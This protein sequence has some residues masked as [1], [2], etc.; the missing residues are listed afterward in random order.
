MQNSYISSRTI[1]IVSSILLIG[2]SWV[3]PAPAAE[4][5]KSYY[6]HDVKQDSHGV[7]APW[8][9]GC[10][11]PLDERLR[12][13]VEVMKRYPWVDRPK[14]VVAAPDFV[15]NSHWSIKSDGT[16]L[17]PPTNDWMCGDLSQRAWS[18]VKGMTDYYAYSGD[19]VAF[20]Y[21]PIT[22][23]YILEFAQT[24]KDAPWPSFPIATPTRGKAYGK[25]DPNARNQLDL[26]AIVG[27]E[28]LRAY[29]LTGDKRYLDAARHWG[30]VFAEKCRFDP[31]IP[32][33]S[34]Y[35]DPS[36]VGWSDELTG[37]ITLILAFLDD[38]ISL[39]HTGKDDA[40]VRARDTGRKYISEVLL[41][42]WLKND[43]WG[44]NYWD[45]DNPVICGIVSMCGDYIMA[46]PQAFPTWKTDLRNVLTLI[47]N[48]NGT[49]P[50][51]HGDMY[52]GA[53]AFPESC[54]CCGTSLSYNQ[55]TAAPTLL[56][57]AHLAHDPRI[58]EIGRRMIIMACYDAD[59][60]GVVKDGL[61]GKTVATGEWSNLAHPWPLCQ[62]MEAIK[63]TPQT[64]SPRSEN[65]IIRTTSVV[66]SV[67]YAKGRI[68]YKLFDAPNE[69]I[70]VLRLSFK[71]DSIS[72]DEQDL[73]CLSELDKVGY[74]KK[75]LDAGDYLVTIRHDGKPHV[76]ITG[77]DPQT[78]VD[79]RDL[80]KSGNWQ[81]MG[82]DDAWNKSLSISS[83]VGAAQSINF[84]GNQVRVIGSVDTQGG[85]AEVYLDGEKQLT[86]IDCWSPL[87]RD[88]QVL[89]SHSGLPN[90]KHEL[91]IVVCGTGNPRSEGTNVYIDA[92]QY[93]DRTA[94]CDFGAGG[95][96]R[97]PQRMIFGYP[98][99][100][101]YIDSK[102]QAWRPATEWVIRSGYGRD[103]VKRAWWTDR[104]SI[105]I[106][107][108]KDEELY[109]YGAHGR[110]FWI[111]LTVAPGKYRVTLH[112]AS[113]PSHTFLERN[114]KGRPIDRTV[115]V[116]INDKPIINKMN[117]TKEAGGTFRA[118]KK[119]IENVAPANGAIEIR[120]KG[121]DD[122]GAALQALEVVPMK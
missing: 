22:A 70:T 15:Y 110:E 21:I 28:F 109:R 39:G 62:I 49:D 54:T 87:A 9:D 52:H 47:I 53:W 96:P 8:N 63:W 115:D 42:K 90:K 82:R 76:V 41:P 91:K 35:V 17:I 108:T 112:F 23:D 40:I 46:N 116:E 73:T 31:S 4:T 10:N 104:R 100:R 44:R 43:T 59:E 83:L 11:G 78:Q 48:R 38:L 117:I 74:L 6:A 84:T 99:N 72:A 81:Q 20:T 56:R 32:P 94:E 71:P 50:N 2:S 107:S 7:I 5:L 89:Y 3:L 65:H 119:T 45:W 98:K 93:S 33:W 67:V 80:E 36:V 66:Q 79:D 111:N 97:E 19:P 69:T 14:A 88:Q 92:I 121:C 27:T 13:A 77:P 61:F 114:S 12:I 18:I 105:H 30:D 64:L 16:I 57:Y 37:S 25:C 1:S 106:G 51:S 113:T 102:G 58:F 60:K 55:Y 95:G 86:L 68:E 118:L 85:R 120:L 26:C 75:P 29:R 34:R 101:D 122:Q 103:T 24:P